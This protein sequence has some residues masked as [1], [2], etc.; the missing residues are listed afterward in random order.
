E[1]LYF[2][3]LEPVQN[4][5]KHAG[6]GA[7][8]TITLERTGRDVVVIVADDGRGF[9][10]A[11]IVQDIGIVN[12]RDRIGAVGGELE[13]RSQPGR[14]TTLRARVPVASLASEEA[15]TQED[16]TDLA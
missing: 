12:M 9:D 6:R 5:T 1:A 3:V 7:R 16:P 10:P 2:F 4:A 8:V 14:G 13:I 15:R 11:V